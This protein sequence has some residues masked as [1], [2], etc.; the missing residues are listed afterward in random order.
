M[1]PLGNAFKRLYDAREHWDQ[2]NRNYFDPKL[3][4]MNVNAVITALRSVTFLLQKNKS[5]I[6]GFDPWYKGWQE[7]MKQDPSLRWLVDARNIIVKERDL[8]LSSVLRVS[9]V[10][11]YIDEEVPKFQTELHPRLNFKTHTQNC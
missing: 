2:A 7:K 10:V 5:L 8:N 11:S 6:D 4:R 9:I 1:N 3:F